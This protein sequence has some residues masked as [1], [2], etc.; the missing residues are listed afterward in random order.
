M[1][2][3]YKLWGRINQKIPVGKYTLVAKNIN[4]IGDMRISKGIE[5]VVPSKAGGPIYF[6]PIVFLIMGF[7]CIGYAIFLRLEMGDYD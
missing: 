6:F 4:H 3:K 5:L 2:T 1:I 7:M